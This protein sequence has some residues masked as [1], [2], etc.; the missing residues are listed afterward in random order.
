MQDVHTISRTFLDQNT[1]LVVP[2]LCGVPAKIS[3][4][5]DVKYSLSTMITVSMIIAS[6][7]PNPIPQPVNHARRLSDKLLAVA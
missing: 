2:Y 1:G 4:E 3:P 5:K 6:L 7:V